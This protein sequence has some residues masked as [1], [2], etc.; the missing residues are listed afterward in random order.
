MEQAM[1]VFGGRP[2][3]EKEYVMAVQTEKK[4]CRCFLLWLLTITVL[5]SA[6]V[7]WL[8]QDAC[9]SNFQKAHLK[10]L[11]FN[12][13]HEKANYNAYC[14]ILYHNQLHGTDYD[15]FFFDDGVPPEIDRELEMDMLEAYYVGYLHAPR[16][17][18]PIEFVPEYTFEQF[19]EELIRIAQEKKEK[20]LA[21]GDFYRLPLLCAAVCAVAM[22]G[23]L[24]S[25]LF[26]TGEGK[27]KAL[28]LSCR[29]GVADVPFRTGRRNS[30][31]V[32]RVQVLATDK[33]GPE[34]HS[35][36][37][38]KRWRTPCREW[39]MMLSKHEISVLLVMADEK[40]HFYLLPMKER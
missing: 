6:G 22:G 8:T 40:L 7:I 32:K 21:E 19:K 25:L 29:E 11:G 2:L 23:L 28:R 5:L 18:R 15:A 35:A 39:K 33:K 37:K 36:V 9:E 3:T 34:F 30:P 17:E 38:M 26:A 13:A 10:A 4:R 20:L 31:W 14:M 27:M 1:D 12:P 16:D 24:V